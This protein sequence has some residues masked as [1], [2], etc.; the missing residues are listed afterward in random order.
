MWEWGGGTE[1]IEDKML[2]GL[3]HF[4]VILVWGLV[5]VFLF[6]VFLLACLL[7]CLLVL[8][9]VGWLVGR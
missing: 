7:S 5:W 6:F 9:V 1:I 4:L 2:C 3:Q 8:L